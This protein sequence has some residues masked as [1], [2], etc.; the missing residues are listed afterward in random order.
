MDHIKVVNSKTTKK[1]IEKLRINYTLKKDMEDSC[2]FVKTVCDNLFLISKNEAQFWT[3]H[4]CDYKLDGSLICDDIM[5]RG[6]SS[7][8]C[9][10]YI[11]NNF[12]E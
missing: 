9:L 10:Q 12:K 5:F 4:I 7:V 3:I 11:I 1:L 2:L 6:Q 8:D